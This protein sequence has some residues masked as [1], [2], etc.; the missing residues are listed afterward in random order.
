MA[1]A[2]LLMVTLSHGRL[3]ETHVN[4]KR[5][6]NSQPDTGRKRWRER[7]RGKQETELVNWSHSF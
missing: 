4:A 5:K 2:T 3:C 1:P 7:G 6:Q